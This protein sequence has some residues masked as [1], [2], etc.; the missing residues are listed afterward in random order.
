MSK[1]KAYKINHTEQEFEER[2]VMHKESDGC[3]IN[4]TD[5]SGKMESAA[6]I[7]I[8]NRS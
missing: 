1:C 7:A 6:A 4:H 8:F 3:E 5:S 2:W